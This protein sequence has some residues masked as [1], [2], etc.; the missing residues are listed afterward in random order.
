MC[1]NSDATLFGSVGGPCW[2]SK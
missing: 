2:G 1:K